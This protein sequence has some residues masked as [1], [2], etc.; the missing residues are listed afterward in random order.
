MNISMISNKVTLIALL[1]LLV[2]YTVEFVLRFLLKKKI[3]LFVAILA[4]NALTLV[5]FLVCQVPM[6]ETILFLLISATVSVLLGKK[7][8]E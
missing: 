3:S 8:E 1:V 6:E 5:L 7:R 4:L 2:L